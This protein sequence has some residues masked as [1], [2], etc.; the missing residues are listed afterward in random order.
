MSR[1]TPSNLHQEDRNSNIHPKARDPPDKKKKH[2]SSTTR[3]NPRRIQPSEPSHP[4]EKSE[5]RRQEEGDRSHHQSPDLTPDRNPHHPTHPKEP[6]IHSSSMLLQRFGSDVPDLACVEAQGNR[7]TEKGSR[8]EEGE[9][10]RREKE[11]TK[12]V[13]NQRLKANAS[14]NPSTGK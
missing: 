7:S 10:K 12:E 5:Q 3:R 13:G 1:H 11:N 6:V 8:E 14:N 4:S 9:E 2:H